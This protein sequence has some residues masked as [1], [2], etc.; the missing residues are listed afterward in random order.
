V[1]REEVRV[2]VKRAELRRAVGD[3]AG[4]ISLL[5]DALE[6]GID[7]RLEP[8]VEADIRLQLL[9]IHETA[10]HHELADRVRAALLRERDLLELTP[11]EVEKLRRGAERSKPA[12]A[13][14]GPQPAGPAVPATGRGTSSVV[15]EKVIESEV[16]SDRKMI[17]GGIGLIPV[18][19]GFGLGGGVL[20]IYARATENRLDEYDIPE[21]EDERKRAI[22]DGAAQN[23]AGI[24]FVAIGGILVLAGVI[25]MGVGYG[26]KRKRLGKH[27][28]P[29]SARVAPSVSGIE[30]RF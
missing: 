30:V 23:G 24:A 4:A 5:T 20:L 16:F 29:P 18:G 22:S 14:P 12:T 19:L 28:H 10:G 27:K 2:L 3:D 6:H 15:E 1:A 7:T 25:L 17:A 11:E 9:E 8:R 26:R 13:T 21:Q